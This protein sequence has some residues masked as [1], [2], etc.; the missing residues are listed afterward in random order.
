MTVEV[1]DLGDVFPFL[2][3]NVS[4]SIY[5]KKVMIMIQILFP[6]F[7]KTT[8]LAILFFF[9]SLVLLGRRLLGVLATKYV[10]GRAVSRLIS[11]KVFLYLF[12]RP[13]TLQ[14]FGVN[15]LNTLG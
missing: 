3:D 13:V 6:T 12:H 8:F 5:C 15:L 14:T 11:S 1:L 10:S 4:V 9:A 7:T 2:L